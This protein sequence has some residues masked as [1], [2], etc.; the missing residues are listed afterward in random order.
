MVILSAKTP[1]APTHSSAKRR[2]AKMHQ[3][4]HRRLQKILAPHTVSI[5]ARLGPEG[6]SP[7]GG[8]PK[9]RL[10]KLARENRYGH[11]PVALDLTT[12][13]IIRV[14]Y[15]CTR[16]STLNS[17]DAREASIL[18]IFF[19]NSGAVPQDH[20]RSDVC[21]GLPRRVQPTV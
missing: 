15:Y 2:N 5:I 9:L 1:N 10:S 17:N 4:I 11:S 16:T 21:E 14:H 12:G 20:V 6:G 8:G 13:T 3:H 7:S 19:R 18:Q